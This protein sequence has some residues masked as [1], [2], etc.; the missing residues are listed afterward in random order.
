[1]KPGTARRHVVGEALPDGRAPAVAYVYMERRLHDPTP[2]GISPD[3]DRLVREWAG[4]QAYMDDQADHAD[5][6]RRIE[7]LVAARSRA[8]G[9]R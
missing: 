2:S 9:E 1:M 6:A 7:A 4:A 5:L 3:V 8:G